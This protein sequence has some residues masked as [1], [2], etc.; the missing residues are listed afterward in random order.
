[1]VSKRLNWLQFVACYKRGICSAFQFAVA[2]RASF[3]WTF[4]PKVT[5]SSPVRPIETCRIFLRTDALRTYGVCTRSRY[6]GRWRL[7]LVAASR[8][9][10]AV[11]CSSRNG[12]C[13]LRR[14]TR[15]TELGSNGVGLE[16]ATP[17]LSNASGT[18]PRCAGWGELRALKPFRHPHVCHPAR[19][20]ATFPFRDLSAGVSKKSVST[21]ARTTSANPATAAALPRRSAVLRDASQVVWIAARLASCRRTSDMCIAGDPKAPRSAWPETPRPKYQPLSPRR[22]L[23][24]RADR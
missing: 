1:L 21:P 22:P 18:S 5:G 12:L 9:H 7:P 11:H 3:G 20:S 13:P 14:Q 15:G 24:G 2:T 4:N 8:A 16:P 6:Q 17:S 10:L 23:R 19:W